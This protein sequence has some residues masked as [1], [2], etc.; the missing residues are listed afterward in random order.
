MRTLSAILILAVLAVTMSFVPA[1][2]KSTTTAA[3]TGTSESDINYRAPAHEKGPSAYNASSASKMTPNTAK[4][5]EMKPTETKKTEKPM[6]PAGAKNGAYSTKPGNDPP[7]DPPMNKMP[8]QSYSL[9]TSKAGRYEFKAPSG[10][11]W[12]HTAN[13]SNVEFMN[14]ANGG[15]SVMVSKTTEPFTASSIEKYQIPKLESN[16]KDVKIIGNVTE[17]KMP[18]GA[19]AFYVQWSR[20]M[21]DKATKKQVKVEEFTYYFYNNGKLASVSCYG[22][23]GT[24]HVDRLKMITDSFK[25]K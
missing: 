14:K 10:T 2:K 17:T 1:C 15:V 16:G 6:Q 8:M 7:K 21:T 3:T 13:G 11:G 24:N 19:K 25:W 12:S 9:Y 5:G 4:P 23:V 20:M 18:D 22:P